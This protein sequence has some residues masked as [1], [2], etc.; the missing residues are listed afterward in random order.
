MI[1]DAFRAT[2]RGS[3]GPPPPARPWL[4]HIASTTGG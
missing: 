1:D 4:A 3:S 2:R